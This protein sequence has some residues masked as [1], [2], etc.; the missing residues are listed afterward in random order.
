M[1]RRRRIHVDKNATS[2]MCKTYSDWLGRQV[3]LQV[4][5]GESRVALRGRIVN[6]SKDALRFR[7]DGRWDVDIFKEMIVEVEAEHY[8]IP[9]PSTLR[10]GNRVLYQP[11][12]AAILAILMQHWSY[13]WEFW[14][15]HHFSKPLCY[16][17]TA[18]TGLAGTVL[19]LL[20]LQ[21]GTSEPV[22]F[23]T[24]VVCG[25]LGLVLSAISLGCLAWLIGDSPTMQTHIILCSPNRFA[26]FLRWIRRP[27]N[28]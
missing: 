27:F 21:A 10:S 6:E 14:W 28:L 3:I 12:A 23:Y 2:L 13:A 26:S 17:A 25:F 19:F 4:D 5:S 15:S 7:L 20:A 8:P 16:K 22:G 9:T 11:H 24:H 1:L 18:W